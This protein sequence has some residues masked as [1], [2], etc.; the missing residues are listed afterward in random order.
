MFI[1]DLT[2]LYKLFLIIYKNNL[3]GALGKID[4]KHKYAE[5]EEYPHGKD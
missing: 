1:C 4:I 2:F 3:I 5:S